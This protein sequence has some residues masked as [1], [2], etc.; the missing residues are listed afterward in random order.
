[1]N[2]YTGGLARSGRS[3]EKNQVRRNPQKNT[4]TIRQ[5][6][7]SGRQDRESHES[8]RGRLQAQNKRVQSEHESRIV[9]ISDLKLS[10][11]SDGG[12]KLTNPKQQSKT[13]KVF[14]SN[15][16]NFNT[17]VSTKFANRTDQPSNSRTSSNSCRRGNMASSY[18]PNYS[19]NVPN[20]RPPASSQSTGRPVG[21]PAY[22]EM[23]NA[24]PAAEQTPPPK[25]GYNAQG[26][27]TL[28]HPNQSKRTKLQNQ[29]AK[30]EAS[31]KKYKEQHRV[32][33]VS[34]T[35]AAVGGGRT[36]QYEARTRMQREQES[37]KY[38]NI[39]KREQWARE[40]KDR[41]DREYAE[42]KEKARNQAEKNA[43]NAKAEEERRKR[44]NDRD[45]KRANEAFLRRFESKQRTMTK[46]Q[47]Y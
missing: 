18:S 27:Y 37:R 3:L 39:R 24:P 42:K 23:P 29:A 41:E 21:R 9:T 30:E 45:H 40:K 15:Y 14:P 28:I 44:M 22:R 11:V 35:P 6:S 47:Y 13:S 4:A 17:D 33:H 36:S 2:S 25:A 19:S 31:Y 38:E 46:D 8:G 20:R 5:V 43:R 32:N 7:L 16:R 34:I 12:S 26:G 10:H 1:M